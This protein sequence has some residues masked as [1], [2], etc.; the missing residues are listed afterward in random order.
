M[1]RTHFIFGYAGNKRQECKYIEP[2]C[3]F[4]GI[5]TIVEPYCGSC[6]FSYYIAQKYP[7]KFK[8]KLV[9]NC[10]NLIKILNKAKNKEE[11]DKFI[12]EINAEK[13]EVLSSKANYLAYPAKCKARG[14]PEKAFFFYNKFYTIRSGLYPL[15]KVGK[16]IPDIP[17]DAGILDFVRTEDVE[18]ICGDGLEYIKE[19]KDKTDYLFFIDPPY[20]DT[21]N[22][23]YSNASLNVYEYFFHNKPSEHKCKMVFAL[24]DI[25]I[26]KLLFK[27]YAEGAIVKEKNYQPSK[28]KTSHIY[29]KN[30]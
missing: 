16:N 5:T 28:K 30:K 26:I 2:L 19:N 14:D 7:K 27:D 6:A 22:Q 29:F 13:D 24:E 21:C 12:D 20:I 9:D 25:W 8:Y 11:Y 4:E 10:E 1:S 3:N 18:F 23:F 15:A 17:K